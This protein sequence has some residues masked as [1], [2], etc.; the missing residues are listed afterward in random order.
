MWF[1]LCKGHL[2]LSMNFLLNRNEYKI[3]PEYDNKCQ[4]EYDKNI[5]QDKSYGL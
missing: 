3:I 1:W 4:K 2:L 5:E